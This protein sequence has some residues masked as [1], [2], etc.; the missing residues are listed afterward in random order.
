[1]KKRLIILYI[2]TCYKT[3]KNEIK[4]INGNDKEYDILS[5]WDRA[6]WNKE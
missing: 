6:K 1:M 2:I 5:V 3:K 4:F